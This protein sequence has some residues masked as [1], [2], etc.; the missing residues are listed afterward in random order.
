M[1]MQEEGNQKS[2]RGYDKQKIN[3]Y[4]ESSLSYTLKLKLVQYHSE[5]D[6]NPLCM[7]HTAKADTPDDAIKEAFQIKG[8]HRVPFII[9]FV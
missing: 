6:F 4:C 5:N 9:K 8:F 3:S 7:G 2:P 1:I